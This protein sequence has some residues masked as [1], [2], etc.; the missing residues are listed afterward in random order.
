MKILWLTWVARILECSSQHT[1]FSSS[2]NFKTVGHLNSKG[3]KNSL[4]PKTKQ[5]GKKRCTTNG[6]KDKNRVQDYCW[7]DECKDGC[8]NQQSQCRKS[9]PP[10]GAGKHFLHSVSKPYM[11]DLMLPSQCAVGLQHCSLWVAFWNPLVLFLTSPAGAL[12]L[13]DF[14]NLFP[15]RKNFWD[16]AIKVVNKVK[17][18]ELRK[19]LRDVFIS[20]CLWLVSHA[21]RKSS[22]WRRRASPSG[23]MLFLLSAFLFN[24]PSKLAAFIV[25]FRSPWRPKSDLNQSFAGSFFSIY[26][27]AFF[28]S[29]NPATKIICGNVDVGAQGCESTSFLQ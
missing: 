6:N 15:S 22:M 27:W 28:N 29:R 1:V 18:A 12:C 4:F 2:L 10:E 16:S 9:K 13:F 25:Y 14:G 23:S 26:H 11:S 17:I 3:S 20:G 7:M 24:G 21:R 5:E 19:S 8:S